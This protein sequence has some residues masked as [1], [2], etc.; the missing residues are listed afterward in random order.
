MATVSPM[1]G[2]LPPPKPDKPKVNA[3]FRAYFRKHHEE[4]RTFYVS[5]QE[6][7]HHLNTVAGGVQPPGFLLSGQPTHSRRA[8]AF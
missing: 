8:L 1:V 3:A 2:S 4:I 6:K 5:Y 7:P